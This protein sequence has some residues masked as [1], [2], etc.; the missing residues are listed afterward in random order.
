MGLSLPA[1][2]SRVTLLEFDTA[3]FGF[4]T[5][6]IQTADKSAEA[7][8]LQLDAAKQEGY[9]VLYWFTDQTGEAAGTQAGGLLADRKRTYARST[10]GFGYFDLLGNWFISSYKE[11]KPDQELY[12]LAFAAGAYSRFQTDPGFG[13][14]GFEK[15][16]AKWIEKSVS[17]ELA[18]EVLYIEDFGQKRAMLT[19]GIKNDRP[20]IGL[21]A[22]A[23]DY[24]GRGMAGDL[25]KSSI[26]WAINRD[27][28][29]VQVVTQGDNRGACKL[30]ESLG[31]KMESEELVF[32]FWL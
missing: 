25:I 28:K 20:D 4:K 10:N 8:Q 32:H 3:L 23:A 11:D 14:E 21:V 13:R 16:Y 24:R 6:R 5:G 9:R 29:E 17:R 27:Y 22:T 18:K 26:V 1:V 15:L 31:Y 2:E 19:L 7:L 12:Q 30:Y